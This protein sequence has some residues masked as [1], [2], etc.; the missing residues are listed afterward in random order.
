MPR[1]TKPCARTD[2]L[3]DDQDRHLLRWNWNTSK[4]SLYLRARVTGRGVVLLHRVIMEA[5]PDQFVDHINGNPL[6][7]RRSNM[8]LC[9]RAGNNFNKKPRASSRAP[10]K[11][12]TQ[13]PSGRWL[14]Q[15]QANK[16]HHVL[17]IFDTPEEAAIAYDN[18][19]IRLHGEFACI[20]GI[21]DSTSGR[22]ARAIKAA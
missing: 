4:K 8:R 1:K 6:D 18:A 17:G 10:Y 13:R 11:G 21:D 20:N 2:I 22:G 5:A 16:V 14:A 15:I 7:C 3:L 9:D 12:I 19:A